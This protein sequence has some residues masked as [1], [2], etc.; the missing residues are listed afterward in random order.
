MPGVST[1]SLILLTRIPVDRAFVLENIYKVVYN[2]AIGG[3]KWGKVGKQNRRSRSATL[4]AAT[5]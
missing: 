2:R 4:H 3:A 1:L 5:D